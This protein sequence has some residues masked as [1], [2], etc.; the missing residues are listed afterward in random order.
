MQIF[1]IRGVRGVLRVG[2]GE[3]LSL[4]P[5]LLTAFGVIVPF[6]FIIGFIFPFSSKAVRIASTDHDGDGH[7]PASERKLQNSDSL[8]NPQC[9]I[10]NQKSEIQDGDTRDAA[11][12]IGAVYVVESIGSLVEG[13]VFSFFMA[14]RFHPFTIMTLLNAGMFALLTALL[15]L[16][17][18]H[19]DDL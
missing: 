11:V 4:I 7:A 3:Y 15:L 18:H 19:A 14:S 9:S 5:L 2:T 10:R 17:D 6:S 1:F 13:L 8:S 12:D 16:L